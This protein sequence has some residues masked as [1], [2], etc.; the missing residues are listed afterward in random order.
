MT[1]L[2]CRP[3]SQQTCWAQF[4]CAGA[5]TVAVDDCP[6]R[7]GPAC[8]GRQRRGRLRAARPAGINRRPRSNPAARWSLGRVCRDGALLVPHWL[9]V[10]S[11]FSRPA[12]WACRPWQWPASGDLWAPARRLP[13]SG[14]RLYWRQ[15][16]K[17]IAGRAKQRRP[18]CRPRWHAEKR[19]RRLERLLD[20]RS[21]AVIELSDRAAS[22]CR[23]LAHRRGHSWPLTFLRP[24]VAGPR[25][26]DH[27]RGG[28]RHCLSIGSSGRPL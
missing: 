23:G 13:G 4:A 28:Y 16:V 8:A 10:H 20:D 18:G 7:P 2:T 14:P 21:D 1:R 17:T 3:R 12:R 26:R 27:P 22:E 11:H 9:P 6:V 19:F 15:R 24:N 5:R 25:R